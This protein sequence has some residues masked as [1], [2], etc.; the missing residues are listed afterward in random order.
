MRVSRGRPQ[1]RGLRSSV[2]LTYSA[3]EVVAV[4]RGPADQD[5]VGGVGIAP[6]LVATLIFGRYGASGLAARHDDVSLGPRA[7]LMEALFPVLESDIR[8]TY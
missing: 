3:G 1:R 7:G 6:D 8:T 4:E 2:V 5:A